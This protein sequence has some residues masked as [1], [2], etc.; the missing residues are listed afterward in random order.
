L[1][2]KERKNFCLEGGL[3]WGP[4]D[5]EPTLITTRPPCLDEIKRNFVEPIK[6]VLKKGYKK[7]TEL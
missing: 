5:H 1:I 6:Q 7:N 4:C 3:N 2:F